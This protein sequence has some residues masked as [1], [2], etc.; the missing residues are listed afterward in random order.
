MV[1]ARVKLLLESSLLSQA[2]DGDGYATAADGVDMMFDSDTQ[3]GVAGEGG[4]RWRCWS[5]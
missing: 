3:P 5:P 1:L 4:W 2:G